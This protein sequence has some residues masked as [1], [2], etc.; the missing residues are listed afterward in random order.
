M[1]PHSS[2]TSA[3]I[4]HV[5]GTSLFGPPTRRAIA[6]RTIA[7]L[8]LLLTLPVVIGIAIAIKLDSRGTIIVRSTRLGPNNTTFGVRKFRTTAADGHVTRVGRVIDHY[9]LD[10][11][12]Q[13]GNVLAGTMTLVGPRP[14]HPGHAATSTTDKPGMFGAPHHVDDEN[15][16]VRRD[17]G[18]VGRSLRAVIAA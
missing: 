16:S 14:Q 2:D 11:L 10:G 13:L 8:I 17:V 3:R 5:R 6:D 7:T 15:W 4:L 18:I 12:P 9:S 1:H